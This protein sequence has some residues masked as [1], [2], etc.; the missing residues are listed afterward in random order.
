MSIKI[1]PKFYVDD[2]L[3]MTIDPYNIFEYDWTEDKWRYCK[4][5]YASQVCLNEITEKEAEH[6]AKI[7]R[8]K[9][10][11]KYKRLYAV[12]PHFL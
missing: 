12:S 4:Y 10:T 6:I 7:Q 8:E 9:R 5:I 3:F 11:D 2:Y 1:N